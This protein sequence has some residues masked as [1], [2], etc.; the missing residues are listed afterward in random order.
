MSSN[1]TSASEAQ[2]SHHQQQA[3]LSHHHAAS[4]TTVALPAYLRFGNDASMYDVPLLQRKNFNIN[5]MEYFHL[6]KMKCYCDNYA[7]MNEWYFF[8]YLCIH[9]CTQKRTTYKNALTCTHKVTKHDD[10]YFSRLSNTL[11]LYYYLI[12][13]KFVFPI[14]SKYIYYP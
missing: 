4:G 6:R 8:T 10:K 9:A 12:R 13:L 3:Q 1:K 7:M 14:A 11:H 5:Y 2:L